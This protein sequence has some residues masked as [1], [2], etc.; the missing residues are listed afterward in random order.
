MVKPWN[1]RKF[2]DEI[3]DALSKVH[4]LS[5]SLAKDSTAFMNAQ[6]DVQAI[7]I[8]LFKESVDDLKMATDRLSLLWEIAAFPDKNEGL[9]EKLGFI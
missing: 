5:C 7:D 9:L 8:E 6:S 2:K 1:P 3:A 4:Q